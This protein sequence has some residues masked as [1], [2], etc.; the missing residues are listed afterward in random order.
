MSCR[1]QLL[2]TNWFWNVV[3]KG[4]GK[5]DVTM[6]TVNKKSSSQ[7][8]RVEFRIA[9]PINLLHEWYAASWF[10]SFNYL[11]LRRIVLFVIALIILILSSTMPWQISFQCQLLAN[12][13]FLTQDRDEYHIGFTFCMNDASDDIE[14]W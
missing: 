1:N 7:R 5:I 11:R 2:T 8:K 4:F 9:K 13:F 14:F 10:C 6:P 3:W 12:N